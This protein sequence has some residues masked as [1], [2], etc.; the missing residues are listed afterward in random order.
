MFSPDGNLY[1]AMST[2]FD[3]LMI[4][5]LWFL[6]SLPLITIGAATTAAYYSMSK[7]V[8]FKTGYFFREFR[9]S[10]KT[11]FKQSIIPSLIFVLVIVILVMDI[12]YVWN[13]RSKLNDALFVILAGISFLFLACV[14][15]FC[16]FLSRFSKRNMALFKMSA[17]GAFRFLPVTVL[18]IV[19]FA[20][21]VIGIYIMPWAIVVFPGVYM[22]LLTFPME[23]VMRRFMKRPEKG[24]P[25]HDAW[26]WGDG[27]ERLGESIGTEDEETDGQTAPGP[28][29]KRFTIWSDTE[30]RWRKKKKK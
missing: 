16:P 18:I 8:R 23:Y 13:N 6:A 7:A 20:A 24:E 22:Y 30:S 26:Y 15:Y 28:P 14:V 29:K 2:T 17:F 4:G 25:G 10:F 11:N 21:M 9:H 12:I 19:V 5:I 27:N 3:V 1:K